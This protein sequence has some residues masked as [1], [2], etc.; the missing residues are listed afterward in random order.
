MTALF[1]HA[2]ALRE[3]DPGVF[4]GELNKNYYL[5]L[6]LSWAVVGH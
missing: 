5:G 4:A 2:M 6:W 1:S 3:V